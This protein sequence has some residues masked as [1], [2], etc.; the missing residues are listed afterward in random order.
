MAFL[1]YSDEK[2]SKFT[3][4][5]KICNDTKNLLPN[6]ENIVYLVILNKISHNFVKLQQSE[7][8]AM[9]PNLNF[10]NF[11][12][13]KKKPEELFSKASA[14]TNPFSCT[15][16]QLHEFLQEKD[17]QKMGNIPTEYLENNHNLEADIEEN[18]SEDEGI[19]DYKLGGY[20]PVH[21]G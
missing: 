12:Q 17:N 7:E 1:D 16:N 6:K 8:V 11:H 15:E 13:Q 2:F 20:H 10:L 4:K 19:E 9:D 3:K 5:N 18:D 14:E 21:I